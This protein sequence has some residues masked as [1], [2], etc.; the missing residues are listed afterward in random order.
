MLLMR[1]YVGMLKKAY[2]KLVTTVGAI[3]VDL[4]AFVAMHFF[5]E[6]SRTRV[7]SKKAKCPRVAL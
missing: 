6:K 5:A 7:K 1:I 2:V 4:H 3:I